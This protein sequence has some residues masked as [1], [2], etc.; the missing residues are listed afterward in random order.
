[1]AALGSSR[2]RWSRH[3]LGIQKKIQHGFL[4]KEMCLECV[5]ILLFTIA[6]TQKQP[7]CPSTEEWIKKMWYIYT[8]EYYSAVNKNEIMSWWII[9]T[10]ITD[11]SGTCVLESRFNQEQMRY[12][13]TLSYL[14]V[15]NIFRGELYSLDK[16]IDP[17]VTMWCVSSP[18]RWGESLRV[19]GLLDSWACQAP[20]GHLCQSHCSASGQVPADGEICT[21]PSKQGP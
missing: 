1:M 3:L 12:Y 21:V 6:K 20:G 4:K 2:K 14:E 17:S 18:G 10:P 13:S 16:Q 15:C 8:M 5:H 9:W 7:K 11:N 19:K